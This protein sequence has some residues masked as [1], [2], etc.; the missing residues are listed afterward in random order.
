MASAAKSIADPG[1]YTRLRQVA[2]GHGYPSLAALHRA[3]NSRSR[4]QVSRSFFWR[5][6]TGQRRSR[7]VEQWITKNLN[8]DF[9]PS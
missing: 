5:V 3:F 6:C 2:M 4:P 8:E 9:P 7:R 1:R